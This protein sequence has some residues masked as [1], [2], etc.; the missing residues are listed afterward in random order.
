MSYQADSEVD[1]DADTAREASHQQ[2][3]QISN[4]A[5][6]RTLEL[7][8]L[9][10]FRDEVHC[11]PLPCLLS[12]LLHTSGYIQIL[13]DLLD[14]WDDC[15][16][17][18]ANPTLFSKLELDAASTVGIFLLSCAL[19]TY[20]RP[21]SDYQDLAGRYFELVLSR[22]WQYFGNPEDCIPLV[23]GAVCFLVHF[24]DRPRQAL[25]LLQSQEPGIKRMAIRESERGQVFI[26]SCIKVSRFN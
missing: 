17:L 12:Y 24:Q 26:Y 8:A 15:G 18:L 22:L 3:A 11:Q 20:K 10:N 9:H 23:L 16:I 14:R 21:A 4:F 5:V 13:D 1:V 7:N 2:L 6:P 25:G 19:M